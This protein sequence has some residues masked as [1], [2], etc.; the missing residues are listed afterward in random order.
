MS[1]NV[2]FVERPRYSNYEQLVKLQHDSGEHLLA[3]LP[4]S[5]NILSKIV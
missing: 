5:I 1:R 2:F 4:V 3:S